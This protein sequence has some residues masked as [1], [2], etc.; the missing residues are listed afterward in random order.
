MRI[1]NDQIKVK[2][3]ER[4]MTLIEIMIVLAIIGGLVAILGTRVIGALDKSKVKQALT[5]IKE[6]EKRLELYNIDCNTYPTDAQGLQALVKAPESEPSCANW[7]PDPY[8]KKLPEDPWG[9][10]FRY[11]SDGA[12]YK[13][14]SL[15]KDGKE[16]GSGYN[17]DITSDDST[18][19]SSNAPAA[20]EE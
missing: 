8:Y 4:G 10:P 13:I 16:G 3:N 2:N 19:G 6:V 5:A 7:G 1:L 9:R 14:T 15:G 18:T 17:K 11:E 12:A 20:K